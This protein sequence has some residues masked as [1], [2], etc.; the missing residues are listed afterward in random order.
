MDR[1]S[2]A[3]AVQDN[4]SKYL[5]WTDV[6]FFIKIKEE[7][8][9]NLVKAKIAVV[10]ANLLLATSLIAQRNFQE[11]EKEQKQKLQTYEQTE[12]REFKKFKDKQD[13]SFVEFLK[14]EWQAMQLMSGFIPDLT[15]KPVQAPVTIQKKIP[16]ENIVEPSKVLSEI[17]IPS[18]PIEKRAESIET[19]LAR[20]QKSGQPISLQF[21]DTSLKINC[22]PDI[23]TASLQEPVNAAHISDFW[24]ELSRTKYDELLD[25]CRTLRQHMQLNDWGYCALVYRLCDELYHSSPNS[26]LLSTWFFLVKSG[27]DARAGYNNADIFLL[28]PSR[29]IIYGFPY[30]EMDGQRYYLVNFDNR[31]N[32]SSSVYTYKGHYP[33][34]NDTIIMEI[35]TPPVI[36]QASENRQ[37]QFHYNDCDYVINLTLK[38]DAIDFYKTYPQTEYAIYF[39]AALSEQAQY[40]LLHDLKPIIEGKS[41]VEAA[42]ILLRFVQTAFE[43]K[44][45]WAQFGREKPFFAEETLFYPYSDCED[46]AILFTYLVRQL[47]GLEVI[48]LD[49]PGHSATAVKFSTEILGDTV[50]YQG[51]TYLVCDPTY[52][53]ANIGQCMPKFVG[54]EPD[55][56]VIGR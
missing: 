21:Y 43:Y 19:L 1:F 8:L 39:A 22:D 54:V 2:L 23:C 56:I 12:G 36:R 7:N 44:N 50:E 4:L 37:L 20:M 14:H 3:D 45:D 10:I 25:Q 52:I 38:R 13:S 5:S 6:I 46:R 35:K 34:S 18:P 41:E 24:A 17:V 28:L 51:S 27:Y 29:N 30:F 11:W 33:N 31:E 53:N 47:L 32:K 26:T 55:V 48:G 9:M 16:S 49:Y 40:S 15:P 42:N